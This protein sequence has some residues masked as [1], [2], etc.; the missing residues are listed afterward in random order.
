MRNAGLDRIVQDWV[1]SEAVGHK[2][3]EPEI[4]QAAADAVSIP[5]LDAWVIGDS[6]HADIAGASTL[7]LRSVWVTDGRAWDQDSYQP[8]R[9]ADDVASAINLVLGTSG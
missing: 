6:P 2:K 3:P 7:G 5:L 1:I 4:F 8:T 9:V